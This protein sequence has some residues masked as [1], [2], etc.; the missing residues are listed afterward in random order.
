MIVKFRNDDV[1]VYIDDVSQA[2][3]TGLYF[4]DYLISKYKENQSEDTVTSEEWN[5]GIN[6]INMAWTM[7][8]EISSKKIIL[9][10][11]TEN[12]LTEKCIENNLPIGVVGIKMHGQDEFWK[13]LVT[14]QEVYLMNN[15]GKTI[16][17]IV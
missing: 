14:C 8:C 10:G 9:P 2:V 16:E 7:A 15:E 11:N 12:L 6:N 4:P 17:R 5:K 3:T 13:R 1:W